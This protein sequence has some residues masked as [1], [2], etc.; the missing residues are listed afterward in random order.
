M[1]DL[2]YVGDRKQEMP[3]LSTFPSLYCKL[4]Y[5]DPHLPPETN[6][7]KLWSALVLPCR[8]PGFRGQMRGYFSLGIYY[9]IL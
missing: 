5:T 3:L 9:T 2:K 7:K 6:K 8:A 1:S 4:H